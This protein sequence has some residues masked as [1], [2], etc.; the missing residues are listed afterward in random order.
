[1]LGHVMGWDSTLVQQKEVYSNTIE[2]M[3]S[4]NSTQC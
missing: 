3:A 4:L 1:M 2:Y